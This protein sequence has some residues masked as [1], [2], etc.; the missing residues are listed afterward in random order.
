MCIRDRYNILIITQPNNNNA[1]AFILW[2]VED[3]VTENALTYIQSE[4]AVM[5]DGSEGRQLRRGDNVEFDIQPNTAVPDA[6]AG[7]LDVT[8]DDFV[9]GN[10]SGLFSF[11]TE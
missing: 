6:P 9:N 11:I 8:M 3:P 2:E 5:V 4:I 10:T 1:Q 7:S